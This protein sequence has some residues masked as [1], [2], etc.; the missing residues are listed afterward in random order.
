[1]KAKQNLYLIIFICAVTVFIALIAVWSCMHTVKSL[2]NV[3]GLT[4]ENTVVC[5]VDA[6]TKAQLEEG[7]TVKI[8]NTENGTVSFIAEQPLSLGEVKAELPE[9]YIDYTAATLNL[10]EWNYKVIILADKPLESNRL[11][12]VSILKS[13]KRPIDYLFKK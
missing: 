3:S 1:M 5:Y 13:A 8:S 10:G 4:G 12:S 7:M 2:I 9:S 6:K 11:V